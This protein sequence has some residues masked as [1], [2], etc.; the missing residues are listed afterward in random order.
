[1]EATLRPYDR[2]RLHPSRRLG[3]TMLYRALPSTLFYCYLSYLCCSEG[4]GTRTEGRLSLRHQTY[5]PADD[6][7]RVR[8]CVPW[9]PQARGGDALR[10]EIEWLKSLARWSA[11]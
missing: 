1:M 10:A 9:L 4:T 11:K 5:G 8:F 7:L 3:S 6:V 2:R